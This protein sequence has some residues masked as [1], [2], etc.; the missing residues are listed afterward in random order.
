MPMFGRSS[1]F[2]RIFA[3]P[4][5]AAKPWARLVHES[6]ER[7]TLRPAFLRVTSR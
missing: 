4:G 7:S 2:R 1:A 3:S 6:S 5:I